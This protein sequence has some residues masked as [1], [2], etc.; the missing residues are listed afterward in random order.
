MEEK[1]IHHVDNLTRVCT[2]CGKTLTEIM[3]PDG[4]AMD[5]DSF[6]IAIAS[7]LEEVMKE[8]KGDDRE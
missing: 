5:Y 3:T 8:G 4:G 2:G 6:V 1:H 7:T